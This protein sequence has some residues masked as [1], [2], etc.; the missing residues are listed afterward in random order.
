MATAVGLVAP[1]RPQHTAIVDAA[2]A[3]AEHN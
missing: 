2:I 3:G 1:N